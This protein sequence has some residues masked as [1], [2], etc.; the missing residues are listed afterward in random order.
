MDFP[1]ITVD[2]IN[3]HL[4]YSGKK[5]GNEYQ[6]QCPYCSDKH[7]DNLKFNES[8]G[9]LY[10]FAS[11]GEHSRQILK[12]IYA[13]N[14]PLNKNTSKSSY[15]H[16]ES[17]EP[18]KIDVFDKEK[19]EELVLYMSECNNTLLNHE[20]SLKYIEAKRGFNKDTISSCG[21]G[22]DL[23]QRKWVIPTFM[24][25]PNDC[26][27]TGFE[28]RPP[29]FSKK[30]TRSKGTPTS[31]AMINC[32]TPK[33]EVLAIVEGYMDGYALFQHLTEQKQ[34]QY[35]HIV[36]PSNGVNSLTKYIHQIEFGKYKKCYLYID[37]DE[38]GDK[39]ALPILEKY[40]F[41]ERINM[42]CGCKDF[43]E[44]YLKCILKR[45]VPK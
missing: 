19:Q 29:D 20:K 34:I 4:G 39:T 3:N 40:P 23:K 1:K 35:Y 37:N 18:E 41:L 9:I 21:I 27:V 44:H 12:D 28:F 33:T 11:N 25:S 16:S 14:K 13:K 30:I 2:M 10:C 24:Y 8:K 32:Y 6:W 7:R 5:V 45:P 42:A 17:Q 26:Y 38:A 22:I 31:M 15:K 36:T 43:N